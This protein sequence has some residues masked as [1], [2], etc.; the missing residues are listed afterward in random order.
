MSS[1]IHSNRDT[2]KREYLCHGCGQPIKFDANVT[3]SISGKAIPLNLD[4][5]QHDCP[6][7]QQTKMN[8]QDNKL[9]SSNI[10]TSEH[11]KFLDTL[12]PAVAETLRLSQDTYKKVAEMHEVFLK[13]KGESVA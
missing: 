8:I 2:N 6:N 5:T 13:S 4:G 10:L 9:Q 7:R 1:N 3:S 11:V 12:G